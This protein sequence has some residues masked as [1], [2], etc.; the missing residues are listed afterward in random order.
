M[1]RSRLPRAPRLVGV[2]LA[3]TLWA[4]SVLAQ[5]GTSRATELF[6]KGLDDMMAG[7]Y[8]TGC[9]ALAESQFLDPRVGTLFTLAECESKAGRIASASA[10]YAEYLRVYAQLPADKRDKQRGREEVSK[11]QVAALEPLV[12]RLVLVLPP[13]A[14]PGTVVK[15]DGEL[16]AATSL[17]AELRVDPGAHVFTA[18]AP[19]RPP[20]ETRIT[21][22]RAER[23]RVVVPIGAPPSAPEPSEPEPDAQP[24]DGSTLRA[25]GIAVGAAGVASLVVGAVTGG[26]ALA[27][28]GKT[29]DDCSGTVCTQVGLDAAARARALGNASTATFVVGGVGVAA[30]LAMFLLAPPAEPAP[31]KNGVALRPW[32][33]ST[34]TTG[35]TVGL[36]GAF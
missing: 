32:V 31:G 2:L 7:R 34:V 30:G 11:A 18:E 25:A 5:D 17:G 16:V 21:V 14:P 22:D 27:E 35:A 20:Q 9:P 23:K 15:Q 4:P 1:L 19:G 24:D 10:H 12:P 28:A 36:E 29:K 33:G 8:A 3:A 26:L 6:K 13:D